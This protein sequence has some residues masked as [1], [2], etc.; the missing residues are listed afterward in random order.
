[1]HKIGERHRQLKRIINLFIKL[2]TTLSPAAL[3]R[4]FLKFRSVWQGNCSN[5]Q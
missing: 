5:I 4:I 3:Q 1:M 2:V